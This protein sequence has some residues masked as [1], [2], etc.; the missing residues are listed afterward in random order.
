MTQ[1][2]DRIRLLHCDDRDSPPPGTL[3]TVTFIDDMGTVYADW[4][5]GSRLGMVAEAGDRI[6][7]IS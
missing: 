5:N 2:G 4:D 7:T 6:E 1:V 3:G